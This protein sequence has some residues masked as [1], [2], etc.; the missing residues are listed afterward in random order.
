[1][2]IDFIPG[3]VH[4]SYRG[5]HEFRTRLAAEIGVNIMDM[6]GFTD[7]PNIAVSWNTIHDDIVPLLDHSDCEGELEPDVCAKVTPRLR[8]LIV[9][10]S[11]DD[12]DKAHAIKLAN[13]MEK[14]ARK[15]RPLLFI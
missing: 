14:C 5:F 15:G 11:N 2:G 7:Y 4:W 13:A 9:P 1:M 10:W 8:E 6:E 12:Y 3:D